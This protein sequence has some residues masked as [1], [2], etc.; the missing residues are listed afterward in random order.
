MFLVCVL[1]VVGWLVCVC[2]CVIS[3]LICA[4][5]CDFGWDGA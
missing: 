1:V 5:L 3:V 4:W 2:W